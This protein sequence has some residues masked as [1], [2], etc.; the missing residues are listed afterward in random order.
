MN[1]TAIEWC[2]S[3]WN[4]IVGCFNDCEYCY[5][6]RLAERFGGMQKFAN[7][8]DESE[9]IR[10]KSGKILPYPHSFSPTFLRY[11]LNDYAN[12][13][14]R[15]IFVC[16]MADLFGDWI[17]DEW[18]GEVFTACRNAPQHRYLFLTKNPER[19][20]LLKEQGKLPNDGN[21]W[22]G[23]SVTNIRQLEQAM[24]ALGKMPMSINFFFSVE[25]MLEDITAYKNVRNDT[26][27]AVFANW[28]IL[29][30]ETGNRK[31]KVIPK[32][33]WVDNIRMAANDVPIF[34]KDSLIPIVGEENMRREFPF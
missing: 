19:Y 3:T 12:K 17:P 20:A 8:F 5:A 32:R 11:H 15:T 4:P 16:S 31:N 33:E 13:A 23:T 30:A 1:N 10:G 18:I 26:F 6:R 29:G 34:M 21:M 25:P 14:G 22:Y 28:I 7:V 27:F 2:N 24:I 9:P